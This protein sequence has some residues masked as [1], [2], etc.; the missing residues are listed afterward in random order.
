M[1]GERN[2]YHRSSN[3]IQMNVKI[4]EIVQFTTATPCSSLVFTYKRIVDITAVGWE[5]YILII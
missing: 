4:C 2:K 1:H 5:Q 3:S